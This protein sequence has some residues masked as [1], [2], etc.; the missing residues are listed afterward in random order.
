MERNKERSVCAKNSFVILLWEMEGVFVFGKIN[1]LGW[2]LCVT[3]AAAK[4]GFVADF[5]DLES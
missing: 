5:W 3:M 1:G 2:S 4:G